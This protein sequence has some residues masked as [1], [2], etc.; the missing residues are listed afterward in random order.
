MSLITRRNFT[1]QLLRSSS[2]ILAAAPLVR[3]SWAAPAILRDRAQLSYGIASGDVSFDSAV[4]W[5][6]ADRRARLL[7]EWATTESFKNSR[8]V[9][10]PWTG[11]DKDFTAKLLL[12]NLPAG[13]RIFYR[14]QFEDDKGTAS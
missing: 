13:Q 6:R 10:G 12:R 5:S 7:V 9:R 14:V 3:A 2:A 11:D 4:I 8:H 1:A